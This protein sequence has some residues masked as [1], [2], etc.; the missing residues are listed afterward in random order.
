MSRSPVP[1]P[2]PL[3]S[4][5][6]YREDLVALKAGDLERAQRA[7]EYLENV[8]RYCAKLRKQGGGVAN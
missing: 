7:K 6:R 1:V 2:D 5:C 8:Q 3:P 4:D